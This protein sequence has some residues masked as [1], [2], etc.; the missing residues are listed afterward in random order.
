MLLALTPD[1]EVFREATARFLADEAPPEVIRRLRA[2]PAGLPDGYWRSG[3]ELGWTS[4]LVAEEH[5]GGSISGAGLTDLTVIAHEFGAH[6]APGPLAAANVVAS[7]LSSHGGPAH[8]DVLA[9]V[10]A[11]T[12]LATCALGEP[13]PAPGVPSGVRVTLRADGADVI[14]D[15]VARPVEYAA[16]SDHILVTAQVA[17]T[18]GFAQVLIPTAAAGVGVEPLRTV[19]LTRRFAAVRFDAVRLPASALVG[20]PGDVAEQVERQFQVALVLACAE[21]VGAMQTAF[22][23]TVKWAFERYSF[24]RPLASYQEIKHR[25]ADLKTWLEAS[26]AISDKAAAAFDAG[27]PGALELASVAKAYTGEFGAELLQDCVQ[28]H[29]GIG[30]TFEHDLHFYLRR[31]TLNRALF[32]TPATHRARVTALFEHLKEV[33]S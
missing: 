32:G 31:G 7:T 16:Q 20:E 24:G 13:G 19:D 1:Q 5:G 10:L 3:A 4:P 33:A 23:L 2:D 8:S 11:G 18:D 22:D 26:H 17:G 9:A 12:S 14:L 25:F 6:A 30:V 15:G 29:G 27:D 21:T 28:L